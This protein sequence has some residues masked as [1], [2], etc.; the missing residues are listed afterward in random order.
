MNIEE[1][2]K[3]KNWQ[4]FNLKMTK[5]GFSNF[6]D[7]IISLN[8]IKPQVYVHVCVDNILH[9]EVLR[10]GKAA[11]GIVDRWINNN[12]GHGSTFLWSIG[13][14]KQYKSHAKRYP[15]YLIF[16]AGLT[17]LNTKLYIFTCVSKEEMN[18]IEKELIR[19]FNPVWEKYKKS[20]K[21]YF[22]MNPNIQEQIIPCGGALKTIDNQRKKP[23]SDNKNIPDTINFHSNTTWSNTIK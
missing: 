5:S 14:S 19:Y 11:N 1:L 8:Q 3:N 21:D 10:I 15:N 18:D 23:F 9:N 17:E 7:E 12:S 22:Q 13:E 4:T 2:L 16:F 20:I 6:S